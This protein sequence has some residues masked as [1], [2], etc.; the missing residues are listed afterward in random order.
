MTYKTID[1]SNDFGAQY[2]QARRSWRMLRLGAVVLFAAGAAG[3]LGLKA[4]AV[5][6][7]TAPTQVSLDHWSRDY[8]GQHWLSLGGE[9]RVKGAELQELKNGEALAYVPVG[10]VED[11]A[12]LSPVVVEFKARSRE[13]LVELVKSAGAPGKRVEGWAEVGRSLPQPTQ[14]KGAAADAIVLTYGTRPEFT[15]VDRF[16]LVACLAVCG[17]AGWFVWQ[18]VTTVRARARLRAEGVGY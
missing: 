10:A 18:W 9:L 7:E 1:F 14:V 15:D 6:A 16:C 8:N 5:Y 2:A 13:A 12:K 11:R 17:V 4:W 3:L